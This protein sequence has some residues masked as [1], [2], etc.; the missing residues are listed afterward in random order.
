MN[1][2]VCQNCKDRKTCAELPG[3]CL[4]LPYALAATVAVMVV[5]LIANSTL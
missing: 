1:V 4:K 2:K 5:V 3:I